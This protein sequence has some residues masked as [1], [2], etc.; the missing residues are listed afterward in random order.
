MNTAAIEWPIIFNRLVES[1][2]A[3]G[4]NIIRK[5]DAS[6][7]NQGFLVTVAPYVTAPFNK[8]GPRL[9][10]ISSCNAMQLPYIVYSCAETFNWNSR[11]VL[12]SHKS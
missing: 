8:L 11:I 3:R 10:L 1:R 12:C 4:A 2:A 5:R 7:S 9:V 6:C